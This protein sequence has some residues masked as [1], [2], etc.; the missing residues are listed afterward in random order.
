[1]NELKTLIADM[2]NRFAPDASLNM[3]EVFQF[4][5]TDD[6]PYTLTINSG[7]CTIVEG[8]DDEASVTLTMDAETFTGLI[9]DELNE[10]QAFMSGKLKVQ[11]NM[12]LATQLKK[13][14]P[15]G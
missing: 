9:T 6:T 1:M 2:E 15:V 3:N 4:N 8:S 13:L 11:G 5:I 10:M 12:M 14:F 7:H